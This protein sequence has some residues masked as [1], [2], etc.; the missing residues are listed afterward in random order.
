MCSCNIVSRVFH[1]KGACVRVFHW[2]GACVRMALAGLLRKW[3]RLLRIMTFGTES[4]SEV[5]S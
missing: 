2:E 3:P 1:W 5:L 4:L